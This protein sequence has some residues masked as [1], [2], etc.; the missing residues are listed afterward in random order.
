MKWIVRGFLL[1][2]VLVFLAVAGATYMLATFNPNDYKTQIA[3]AVTNATGRPFAI[4]GDIKAS[5]FPVLGF[6]AQQVVMGSPAG[7]NDAEFVK[8]GSM[9]AGVKVRPLLEKK[10]ELTRITLVEPAINI[11]KLANGKTNME[12]TRTGDA[13]VKTPGDT[14]DMDLSVEEIEI[15]R[16]RVLYTDKAKGESWTIDPLNLNLPGFKPGSSTPV[17]IDMTMKRG[18]DMA[19]RVNAT[20]TM[21]AAL[22]DGVFTLS[23]AKADIDIKSVALARNA[24]V[25]LRGDMILNNKTQTLE[26]KDIKITWDGTNISSAVKVTNFKEPRISFTAAAPS[27]DIDNLMGALAKKEKAANDNK[28][29][30]PFDLLRTLG[31]DGTITIETLKMAGLAA[32]GVNAT[33]AAN[34]GQLKIAPVTAR[35]YE[36]SLNAAV[37]VDARNNTPSLAVKG[38]LKDVQVGPILAAKMGSDYLTGKAGFKIDLQS[39]GRSMSALRSAAGGSFGFDFG[40]GYV[41]KWQL[42]RLINQAIAYFETG[43]LTENVSDKIHFTSLDGNFT[44]QNGVFRNNDLVLLAPRSHAL[45][46]G[47]VNFAQNNVDYTVRVGLGDDPA[48]ITGAKHIPVRISGPLAKPQYGIDV[49]ALVGQKVEEKK[50]E[51]LNK[52]FDRLSGQDKKAAPAEPSAAAGGENTENAAPSSAPADSKKPDPREQL[53][54]GIFGGN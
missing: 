54:R 43:Q 2:V 27:L 4:N 41:N 32:N 22:G 11:V 38:D 37:T 26:G 51:L 14:P 36:G 40:E 21:N 50:Q 30:L 12:F 10:I 25:K 44:G 8:V 23:G 6:T 39:R 16:A 5:L 47:T 31:I 29:L 1:L 19:V 46:S 34:G 15:S 7:F 13:T 24:A 48:K 28:D 9:Q 35:L 3:T 52:A 42:S 49:Q 33:I 18:D 20:A 45:G 17:K 53:L